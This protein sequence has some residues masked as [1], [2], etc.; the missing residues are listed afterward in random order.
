MICCFYYYFISQVLLLPYTIEVVKNMKWFV[1]RVESRSVGGG[2]MP[3]CCFQHSRHAKK[4]IRHLFALTKVKEIDQNRDR[5]SGSA[6]FGGLN[7][8]G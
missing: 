4:S 1:F 3:A 6:C 2:G 7:Q 8:E 5:R